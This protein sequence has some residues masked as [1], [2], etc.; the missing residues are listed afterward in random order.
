MSDEQPK[1]KPMSEWDEFDYLK[2]GIN[3][4][5]SEAKTRTV[6]SAT[7]EPGA[8]RVKFNVGTT[9]HKGFKFAK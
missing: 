1:A 6:N 7:G 2:A 5:R 9:F 3:V 4:V 8:K